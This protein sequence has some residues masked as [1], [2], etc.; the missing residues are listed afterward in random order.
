MTPEV[1]RSP[2]RLLLPLVLPGIVVGVASGL[3]LIAVSELAKVIQDVIWDTLPA[4]L[5]IA[6]DSPGWILGVL[7]LTGLVVGLV[8]TFVPGHA[9][10]DPATTDYA[11]RRCRRRAAGPRRRAVILGER[12]AGTR[13]D[14]S[15]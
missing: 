15:R 3:I 13:N 7:T 2:A 11:G 14:P 10:P 5:G 1:H 6:S 8:V 4:N 12:R 9:G